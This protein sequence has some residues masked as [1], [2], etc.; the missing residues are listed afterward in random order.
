MVRT[1]LV[2]LAIAC[3]LR[4][5]TFGVNSIGIV[6]SVSPATSVLETVL[7]GPTIADGYS[8]WKYEEQQE[9]IAVDLQVANN[10]YQGYPFH[11]NGVGTVAYNMY[12]GHIFG[13]PTPTNLTAAITTIT[14]STITIADASKLNLTGL[15]GSCGSL[16]VGILVDSEMIRVCATTA[17]SG[18]ATLTVAYNGRGIANATTFNTNSLSAAATHLNGATVYQQAV[19]GTGTQFH[20]DTSWGPSGPLAIS[21]PGPVGAGVYAAGL[22]TVGLGSSSLTA[23]GAANWSNSF[24]TGSA[25]QGSVLLTVSSSSGIFTGEAVNGNGIVAGTTVVSISGTTITLSIAVAYTLNSANLVFGILAGDMIVLTNATHASGTSFPWWAMVTAN[26]SGSMTVNRPFP[27]DGDAGSYTYVIVTPRYVSLEFSDPG[28]YP[29]FNGTYRGLFNVE[30]VESETQM[31]GIAGQGFTTWIAQGA[32]LIQSGVHYTYKDVIGAQSAAGPNFYGQ[33]SLNHWISTLGTYA[34]AKNLSDNIDNWYVGDPEMFGGFTGYGSPLQWGG[35]IIQGF[36]KKVLDSTDP[37]Q[38]GDLRGWG[39]QSVTNTFYGIS[40]GCNT[41]DTRNHAYSVSPLAYL[42]L[43]DPDSSWLSYW[44]TQAAIELT[45]DQGC[46]RTAGQGYTLSALNSFANTFNWGSGGGAGAG[47]LLTISS[48][49]SNIATGSGFTSTFP[50]GL[51]SVCNG[52]WT[53]TVAV[54]HN[55]GTAGVSSTT[56][57]SIGAGGNGTPPARLW[58]TDNSGYTL[59][60]QYSQAAGTILLSGIWGGATGVFNALAETVF[61]NPYHGAGGMIAIANSN[62]DSLAD[63]TQ[64]SKMYGC[65]IINSTTAQFDRPTGLNG[66]NYQLDSYNVGGF[67]QQPFFYGIWMRVLRLLSNIP[68]STGTGFGAMLPVGGI[69]MNTYGFDIN[70]AGTRYAATADFCDPS[71]SPNPAGN[72]VFYSIQAFDANQ[73][74][75]C[76]NNQVSPGLYN[77]EEIERVASAE[78]MAAYLEDFRASPTVPKMLFLDKVYSLFGNCTLTSP[79]IYCDS[80]FVNTSNEMSVGSLGGFKWAGFFF[81]PVSS[82]RVWPALRAQFLAT[83]NKS[84]VFFGNVK[85]FGKVSF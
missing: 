79:G 83:A 25:T 28:S 70:T 11:I 17:S 31:Y 45:R 71:F 56:L 36:Q 67:S 77:G 57:G 58:I 47:P 3:Q 50:T 53:G 22:A 81:G 7:G 33:A 72:N 32:P 42:A 24:P 61:I 9:K 78:G 59:A 27:S 30:Y 55:S 10:Y 44:R 15:T 80:A 62:T 65:Y 39:V 18:A 34:P 8:P 60:T 82:P 40:A 51:G 43:Y 73:N 68:G 35:G 76:G 75:I 37:V 63:N 16:A 66:N 69:W 41:T 85:S 64:L 49:S 4:A 26:S 14:Q 5:I 19:I 74:F 38:W 6:Q 54:T 21:I 48:G 84:T 20:S 29:H 23:F 13:G 1:A 52:I 12:D 2:F 46:Q